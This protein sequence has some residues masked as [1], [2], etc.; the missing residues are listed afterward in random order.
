MTHTATIVFF[1]VVD[2]DD[3]DGNRTV[4]YT[5]GALGACFL[6]LLICLIVAVCARKVS[7]GRTQLNPILLIRSTSFRV[8]VATLNI[9]FYPMTLCKSYRWFDYEH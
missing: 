4:V 7:T 6:L 1:F 5:M 9:K 2:G 8:S 3:S